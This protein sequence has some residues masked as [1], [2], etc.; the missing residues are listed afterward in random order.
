MTDATME[1]AVVKAIKADYVK[2]TI[3]VTLEAPLSN[4]EAEDRDTLAA[5]AELE[6][7]VDIDFS[8]SITDAPLLYGIS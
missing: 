2:R 5:W 3:T 4:F 7:R 6:A 8:R 1:R